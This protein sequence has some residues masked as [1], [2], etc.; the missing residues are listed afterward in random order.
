MTPLISCLRE[1]PPG[2]SSTRLLSGIQVT[3]IVG[4]TR[5]G[6]LEAEKIIHLP[7]IADHCLLHRNG[8]I[9]PGRFDDQVKQARLLAH[10]RDALAVALMLNRVL[11]WTSAHRA[12]HH[13]ME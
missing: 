2:V 11:Q 8:P 6:S 10:I 5:Y 7:R 4:L 9:E 12:V 3:S 13:H 1:T